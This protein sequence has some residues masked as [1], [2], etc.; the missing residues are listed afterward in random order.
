MVELHHTVD[1]VGKIGRLQTLCCMP[2]YAG[3]SLEVN[4]GAE[5][6]FS[7]MRRRI[8][9]DAELTIAAFYTPY[10]HFWGDTW[11][12]FIKGGL[13]ETQTLT[14]ITGLT[15]VPNYLAWNGINGS[16]F[17][18]AL[19]GYN[20]IWNRYWRLPMHESEITDTAIESD[21]EGLN[22]GRHVARIPTIVTG[23]ADVDFVNA[24]TQVSATSSLDIIQLEQVKARYSS[25][26][27]REWFNHEYY[28]DIMEGIWGKGVNIDADQRPELL[29]T[30]RQ[31]IGGHNKEGLDDAA[32]G[33]K[34][35]AQ[36]ADINVMIPRKRVIEHG[37]VHVMATVRM[38]FR[39]YD[40]RH[41]FQRVQNPSYK[42]IG[43]DLKVL[44]AEGPIDENPQD[45][46]VSSDGTTVIGQ[47]PYGQWMRFHPNYIH[48]AYEEAEGYPFLKDTNIVNNTNDHRFTCNSAEYDEMFTSLQ[49]G[50]F[51][52]NGA[53]QI[54]G[55]RAV[56]DSLTSIYAGAR[57]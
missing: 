2:V 7:A 46:F 29:W 41:Y 38:P 57:R 55:M 10:R 31:W 56:P 3:D 30:H 42:E 12:D 13:K 23:A 36:F 21:E 35:G 1:T 37:I 51:T 22:Y 34:K 33:N 50:H 11:V 54:E 39:H 44:S 32:L 45:F 28:T 20:R 16:V 47:Q 24:D 53:F 17:R 25:E 14:N 9:S 6:E 26:I 27:Q 43:A 18:P 15:A 48:P 49:Y 5:L 40:E 8:L 19:A 4:F 52:I